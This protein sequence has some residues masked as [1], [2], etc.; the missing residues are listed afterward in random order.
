MIKVNIASKLF[1][2][3]LETLTQVEYRIYT[4]NEFDYFI[5]SLTTFSFEVFEEFKTSDNKKVVVFS[6]KS[7]MRMFAITD[8]GDYYRVAGLR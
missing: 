1:N 7:S 2:G 8:M 4:R 5:N 3:K 6:K